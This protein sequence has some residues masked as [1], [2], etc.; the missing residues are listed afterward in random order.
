MDNHP[1][2]LSKE[3]QNASEN[4]I[5]SDIVQSDIPVEISSE[6]HNDA[7]YEN[8]NNSPEG[9]SK[10]QHIVLLQKYVKTKRFIFL[11]GKVFALK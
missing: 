11:I 7:I 10:V 4:E 5:Y 1:N 8:E 9:G 2:K 3:E 6:E